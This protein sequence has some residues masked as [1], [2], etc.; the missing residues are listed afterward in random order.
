MH[1]IIAEQSKFSPIMPSISQ[2]YKFT[3]F[4]IAQA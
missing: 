1:L 4:W 3:Y 2:F